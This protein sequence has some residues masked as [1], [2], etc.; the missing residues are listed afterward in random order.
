MCEYAISMFISVCNKNW[1]RYNSF[2]SRGFHY[3]NFSF[4]IELNFVFAFFQGLVFRKN[5]H[6]LFSVSSD[7]TAKIW[8]LDEMAY[9]ET[10][11][12]Y[13]SFLLFFFPILLDKLLCPHAFSLSLYAKDKFTK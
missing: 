7:H 10:L 12:V 1:K 9:V 5:T 6:Q 2:S 13:F 3:V 11:Y 8:N 4:W